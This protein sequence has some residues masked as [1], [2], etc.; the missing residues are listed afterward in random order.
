MN[1][2]VVTAVL[3]LPVLLAVLNVAGLFAQLGNPSDTST[4]ESLLVYCAQRVQHGQTLYQDYHHFPYNY[5]P[6]TPLFT[7]TTG[8]VARGLNADTE[9]L[10]LLGRIFSLCGCFALAFLLYKHERKGTADGFLLCVSGAALFLSSTI[11]RQ[12]GVTSR[13]DILAVLLSLAGFLLYTRQEGKAA[14]LLAIVLLVLAFLAK[15]SSLSAPAA[16]VLSQTLGKRNREALTVALGFA[17]PAAVLLIAMHVATGGLSTLNIVENNAAPMQ[18]INAKLIGV[19][20]LQAAALPLI[21]AV[22]GAGEKGARDP[23]V[24]Y[25]IASFALA[26][27]SSSKL[28]SNINYYLEPLAVSCLLVPSG[29]RVLTNGSKG[30][31]VVCA[32]IV[33]LSLPAMGIIVYSLQNPGFRA[34]KNIR[35]LV[36]KTEG[37]LLTDSPRLAFLSRQQFLIDPFPFSYLEKQGRWDSAD[38][39]AMLD[40]HRIPLVVL[41]LPIEDSLSWQGAKRLPLTIIDAVKRNYTLHDRTDSYYVYTP[42]VL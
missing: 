22:V 11:L 16:L 1:G 21:L 42:K 25:L 3:L 32:L 13:P 17:I 40:Q 8:I 39:V 29:I 20:F 5:M 2:R 24:L 6:Y 33:V 15:Q 27:V 10:F 37:P 23:A 9:T 28:G 36:Q 38:V 30:S 35:S 26:A 41:N 34:D 12:W 19:L 18:W 4:P 14:R 31:L 7:W